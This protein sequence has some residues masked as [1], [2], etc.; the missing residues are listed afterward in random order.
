M[1]AVGVTDSFFDLGGH[2]LLIVQV[3]NQLRRSFDTN[4][5]IAQMFQYPTVESLAAYVQ[6]PQAASSLRQAQ[7]R[8]LRQQPA[9]QEQP[10]SRGR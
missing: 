6:Q 10:A 9:L 1:E 2:S 7:A 8:A 3:H 4:I 5:T